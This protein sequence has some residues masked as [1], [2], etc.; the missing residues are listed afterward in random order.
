[1]RSTTIHIPDHLLS[2]IDQAV[3]EKGIS[4]NR[5]IVQACERALDE[6]AGKWPDD[7]FDL[8]LCAEDL[9]LLSEGVSEMEEAIVSL[10]TSRKGS[11]L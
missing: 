2:K 4:R 9:K 5:F 10:R 8:D 11:I 7:F 3:K 1:M 6:S